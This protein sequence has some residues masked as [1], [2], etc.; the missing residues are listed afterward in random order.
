MSES[1][2]EISVVIP[3]YDDLARLDQCLAALGTQTMAR[4]RFEVIVAD[5]MSPCG[6]AAVAAAVAGRARVVFASDRGAGPARNAGVAAARGTILAF[7][8]ADCVPAPAW[9]NAAVAALETCDLVGGAM[10]VA[11]EPGRAMSGAQAFEAVF[12]FDNRR[13]VESM[14]FSVTANLLCRRALFDA[15]GGF[16]TGVSEDLDWCL[17]AR[18]AGYRIGYAPGAIVAHPARADWPSLR[19]KWQRLS[20]ESYA[21][22]CERRGGRV[23]WIARSLLLP[24]SIIAHAPRIWRSSAVRSGTERR[25]ALMTLARL[26]L[27]RFIA[28]QRLWRR[29]G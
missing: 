21:L 5:N 2:P 25:A 8:D 12:A 26:R 23:R 22:A 27:W 4:A 11:I 1:A 17:R 9:L 3:H 29:G 18:A 6:G 28:A 10:Q 7:T 20:A 13:Y 24:L 19:Q 16:R 15:V 14:G